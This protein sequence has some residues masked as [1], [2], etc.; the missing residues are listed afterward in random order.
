[1]AMSRDVMQ[2]VARAQQRYMEQCADIRSDRDLSDHGRRKAL[3]RAY[4]ETQTVMAALRKGAEQETGRRRDELEKKLFRAAGNDGTSTMAYRD[5]LDRAARFKNA[6]DAQEDLRR[7]L[8]HGDD[9]LARAI[10]S[11]ALD[12]IQNPLDRSWA[13]VV[14]EYVDKAKPDLRGTVDEYNSL[15]NGENKVVRFEQA[16]TTSVAK[17]NELK[18]SS[19][20]EIDSILRSPADL[21]DHAPRQQA[22]P[23]THQNVSASQVHLSEGPGE[24]G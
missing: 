5:A 7:A 18:A 10:F 12:R 22:G 2:A 9:S 24:I 21:Q 16:M 23:S 17:P 3:A 14:D 19:D 11:T 8:R 1:M 20:A 4:R 15:L 13:A 6:K